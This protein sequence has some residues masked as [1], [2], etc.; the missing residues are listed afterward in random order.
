MMKTRKDWIRKRRKR[1]LSHRRIFRKLWPTAE[2]AALA[3]FTSEQSRAAPGQGKAFYRAIPAG[4]PL[5]AVPRG[6]AFRMMRRCLVAKC[7]NG[8]N[9]DEEKP[10]TTLKCALNA[11]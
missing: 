5:D 6:Q 8:N 2:R 3:A 9:G 7:F 10:R 11:E 4:S 1:S